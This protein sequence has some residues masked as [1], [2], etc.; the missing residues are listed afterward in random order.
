[1]RFDG[2]SEDWYVWSGD[3]PA[4]LDNRDNLVELIMPGARARPTEGNEAQATWDRMNR[5]IF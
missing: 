5:K 3:I 2:S 1:M 4:V